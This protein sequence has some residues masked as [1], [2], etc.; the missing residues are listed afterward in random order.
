[1]NQRYDLRDP[2]GRPNVPTTRQ[3]LPRLYRFVPLRDGAAEPRSAARAGE[4]E[5][6][7]A[8]RE[9]QPGS[10]RARWTVRA[11]DDA[12]EAAGAGRARAAR[13]DRGQSPRRQSRSGQPAGVAPADRAARAGR[14]SR[15]ARV[16]RGHVQGAVA[17]ARHFSQGRAGEDRF[18]EEQSRRSEDQARYRRT[19]RDGLGDDLADRRR[20]RHAQP[21]A[22]HG[23]RGA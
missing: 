5:H 1:M 17:H 18:A 22:R 6:P 21:P 8:D 16:G 20:R 7:Q 4:A 11:A 9:L 10:G 15:P 2:T 14:E 19:D 3:S 12:G 23:G 13:Q